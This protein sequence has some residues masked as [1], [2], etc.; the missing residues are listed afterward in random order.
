MRGIYLLSTPIFEIQTKWAKLQES[1]FLS[2]SQ[3]PVTFQSLAYTEQSDFSQ[4]KG[5]P[6]PTT[7]SPVH[8]PAVQ[9]CL[10]E[11]GPE[12]VWLFPRIGFV[13]SGKKPEGT[14][15]ST[16]ALPP[17]LG[18]KEEGINSCHSN[19]WTI[20]LLG[21]SWL[22]YIWRR[23]NLHPK[24]KLWVFLERVSPGSPATLGFTSGVRRGQK[25]TVSVFLDYSTFLY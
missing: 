3:V 23:K 22:S 25:L 6:T 8:F 1:E 9:C 4:G 14:L 7:H 17:Q 2:I 13:H 10:P 20:P 21:G 18:E 15:P 19:L 24:T 16:L 5:A 11:T 12:I